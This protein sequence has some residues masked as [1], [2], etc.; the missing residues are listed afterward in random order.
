MAS[1]LRDGDKS[2]AN[3]VA[4]RSSRRFHHMNK[5]FGDV[6]IFILCDLLKSADLL[7]RMF[8]FRTCFDKERNGLRGRY[9][10]AW[11]AVYTF[12][13]RPPKTCKTNSFHT[14]LRN[15]G[16]HSS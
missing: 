5:P 11:P 6:R 3:L 14:F 9:F 10:L 1:N 16:S 4:K 8:P 12:S 15:S 7:F 2:W 13:R